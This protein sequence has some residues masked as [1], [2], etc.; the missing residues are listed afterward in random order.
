MKIVKFEAENYQILKAVSITPDGNVINIRGKNAQGKSSILDAI[1]V[2]IEGK[3]AAPPKPIRAGQEQ[4]RIML[5]LGEVMVTRTFKTGEDGDYTTALKVESADGRRFPKP[6]DVLNG[7]L[8]AIGFDPF[9]FTKMTVDKQSELLLGM[10]ALPIDFEELAELDASDFAKRRDVNRD[11]HAVKAQYDAIPNEELPGDIPDRD[12]LVAKLGNASSH[13]L[14]IEREQNRRDRLAEGRDAC[15]SDRDRLRAHAEALRN[16]AAAADADADSAN[17]EGVALEKE[18]AGLPP[19]ETPIDVHELQEEI[20]QA[21]N[22]AARKARMDSKAELKAKLD[23]L[24][25]ESKGYT[26]AMEAREKL[27]SEALEQAVMPIEGLGFM[28]DEKGKPRVTF[29][30]IP[31]E[32]ISTAE[33]LRASTA[34]AMAANPELRVLRIKDGSLLDEDS[35]KM[36]GELA[37]AED[38]Q[39]WIESVGTGGVGF[40]IEDGSIVGA[41]QEPQPNK[42]A[43]K[44]EATQEKLV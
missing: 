3:T 30:A 44:Q 21:E 17:Q 9:G 36:I 31:F 20:R 33:Q 14:G 40:T 23:A 25:A 6:Q 39:V 24:R 10:V 8:G 35:L 22:L 15:F 26:E 41:E 18:I 34:I 4:A 5:D 43:A 13:N 12:A 37:S 27:R 11:G 38:Y 32:Q 7:L 19:I 28:I 29:K 1:R 2:A 42:P 16:Q